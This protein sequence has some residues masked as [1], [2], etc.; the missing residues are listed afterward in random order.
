LGSKQITKY[1]NE[2]EFSC[3]CR[4]GCTAPAIS[5][6]LVALLTAIR[7]DLGKPMRIS[8]GLRCKRKNMAIA[9][10]ALRSK[11]LTGEA[12]DVV[13]KSHAERFEILKLALKYGIT[14]IGIY[15]RHIHLDIGHDEP[16][17]WFEA[18]YPTSLRAELSQYIR[19]LPDSRPLLI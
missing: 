5:H 16:I 8:S 6:K 17:I 19:L 3:G 12:A 15:S 7:I 14:G 13:A 10:A 1:F 9:G 18:E 2:D 4:E 11:H